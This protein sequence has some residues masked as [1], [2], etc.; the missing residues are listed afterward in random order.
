MPPWGKTISLF[1]PLTYMTDLMRYSIQGNSY[2]PILLDFAAIA[3]FTVIFMALAMF[4]HIRN[5]PKRL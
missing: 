1:S 4:I 2:H 5:M 3:I